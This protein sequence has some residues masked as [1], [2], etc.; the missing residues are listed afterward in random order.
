MSPA[1]EGFIG[2]SGRTRSPNASVERTINLYAE[3]VESQR[4]TYMLLSMP[5]LRPVALL[6]S[7]PVRGLYQSTVG[8][9]FATTSTNLFEIF[10]GWSF[11]NRGTIPTGTQPTSMT[12]NGIHLLLSVEGVGMAFDFTTNVLSTIAPSE[13]TLTFGQVAY[14]DGYFLTNQPGTRRFWYSDVLDATSW[15]ALSFYSAEARADLLV[16]LFVDHR[17]VYLYGSQSIE[18]W[19]STGNSLDPFARR[20]DSFIEQG[21]ETPWSVD[22]LDNTLFHLGGTIR[23]EGPV[24]TLNG[25][26][27]VRVS[28]HALETAMGQMTTVGDAISFSARHGGHALFV[29]DFP[30]GKQTWAFDTATQAWFELAALAEDGSLLPYP[31]NQH[32]SAFGEHLF[33]DRETGQIYIWDIL[34]HRYG[35]GVRLCRRTSPHVRSEQ[36]R[37]R[38]NMFRLEM[39]AGVGLDA[40][41]VPGT[42][43]QVMLRTSSDGGHT[44]GHGRWRFC[45]PHWCDPAASFLVSV[46]SA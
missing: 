20:S 36:K 19:Y 37:L 12:D 9:V 34:Y 7:G 13:P 26:S 25:Y 35:D 32:C 44:W 5:G 18:I 40:G 46:R 29:I 2:P 23:G 3:Q 31:C 6:P 27:P 14:I 4:G 17:E 30:T 10:S 38:Y 28:T 15:S 42:D 11:L 43:P 1:L 33:G 39:E 16:T 41:L 24:W 22:A 21:I 45:G 8:R